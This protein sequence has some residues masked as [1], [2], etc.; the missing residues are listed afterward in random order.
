MLFQRQISPF[1]FFIFIL[2]YSNKTSYNTS[3]IFSKIEYFKK[4]DLNCLKKNPSEKTRDFKIKIWG[5]EFHSITQVLQ[6]KFHKTFIFFRTPKT[7]HECIKL[8]ISYCFI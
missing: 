8:T 3:S 4:K 5:L 2:F 1:P 6:I 7:S